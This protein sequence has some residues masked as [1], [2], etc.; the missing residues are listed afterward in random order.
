MFINLHNSKE[1]IISSVKNA[2]DS[3][4]EC[5]VI[6]LTANGKSNIRAFINAFLEK[7]NTDEIYKNDILES[8]FELIYNALKANYSHVYTLSVLQRKYPKLNDI[9]VSGQYFMN[10]KLMQS[11]VKFRR[12]TF[13]KDSIKKL[14][15]LESALIKQLD[16]GSAIDIS[17]YKE[18]H[19][20]K[21]IMKKP[22]CIKVSL[23]RKES[24][25]KCNVI[26]EAPIALLDLA[27]IYEK[28]K[29]FRQYY[30]ENRL[31][32]FYNENLDESES[33][34]FGATLI[35]LR[36]LNMGLEPYN[37]FTI[38]TDGIHTNASISFI[39]KS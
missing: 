16:E 1:E 3:T 38:L 22:V 29:I 23:E 11:Y 21:E 4:V 12:S 17:K 9:I 32:Q 2:S 15:K 19:S 33:A 20:F 5:N 34:G 26:N 13:V 37:Y 27:R 36:L 7:N 14:M 8:I 6:A 24:I 28:R 10:E 31:Y 25:C 18:L 30:D 35:D 39:V